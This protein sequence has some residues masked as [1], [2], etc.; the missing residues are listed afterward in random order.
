VLDNL[1]PIVIVWWIS[2]QKSLGPSQS[3]NQNRSNPL[4]NA[5]LQHFNSLIRRPI[6]IVWLWAPMLEEVTEGGLCASKLGLGLEY[7]GLQY[8]VRDKE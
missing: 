7:P 2:E 3:V 6:E 1:I 8:D 5:W 4:K